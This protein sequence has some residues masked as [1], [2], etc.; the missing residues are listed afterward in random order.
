MSR[1]YLCVPSF[2]E[3]GKS[4]CTIIKV[5]RPDRVYVIFGNFVEIIAKSWFSS[6]YQQCYYSYE[7]MMYKYNFNS[8]INYWAITFHFHIL[9]ICS[10]WLPRTVISPAL[11][12]FLLITPQPT[13]IH[14]L[15]PTLLWPRWPKPSSCQAQL[16]LDIS[17]AFNIGNLSYS[18]WASAALTL[19]FWLPLCQFPTRLTHSWVPWP[20][21][22]PLVLFSSYILYLINVHQL[23]GLQI[24][25]LRLQISFFS[26]PVPKACWISRCHLKFNIPR[27]KMIFNL[28]PPNSSLHVFPGSDATIR[29]AEHLRKMPISHPHPILR[30]AHST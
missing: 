8:A 11:I 13:A 5:G 18:L 3:L 17:M 2:G 7:K 16:T 29:P 9:E 1:L 19:P 27:M 26:A 14:Y 23:Q 28:P 20:L 25:C 30:S 6:K 15:L 4:R 21:P 24:I 10:D 22:Q 12:L